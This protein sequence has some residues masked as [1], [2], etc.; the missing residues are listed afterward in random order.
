MEEDND[1]ETKS[2]NEDIVLE[3]LAFDI[4]KIEIGSI[5]LKYVDKDELASTYNRLKIAQR[6]LRVRDVYNYK[7]ILISLD[8]FKEHLISLLN[9]N[10]EFKE[11]VKKKLN[12]VN[13]Q[14]LSIN[15][16][17]FKV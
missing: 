15:S 4:H 1:L 2:L 12:K 14:I 7:D 13:E 5:T 16:V 3:A 11:Y 6:E 8:M 9:N 10:N 17:V